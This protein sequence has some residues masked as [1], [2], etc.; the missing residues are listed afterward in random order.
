MFSKTEWTMTTD[1][2]DPK[3]RCGFT[4]D[5]FERVKADDYG[6]NFLADEPAT[7]LPLSS[8][9]WDRSALSQALN[10]DLAAGDEG[11]SCYGS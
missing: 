1:S 7:A 8:L 4:Y 3:A 5:L 11:P 2:S 9:S 6:D 10:P